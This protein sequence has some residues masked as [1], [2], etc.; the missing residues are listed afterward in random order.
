MRRVARCDVCSRERRNSLHDVIMHEEK[1]K[2]NSRWAACAGSQ[3]VGLLDRCWLAT[4][5]T[6][7]KRQAGCWAMREW[8]CSD[9]I[10]GPAM[11]R[12]NLMAC[13]WAWQ[14]L[15]AWQNG[16]Q[17]GPKINPIQKRT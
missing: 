13:K 2:R 8:A 4:N 7:G 5:Q 12:L 17:D 6:G 1:R 14:L 11:L 3:E 15:W 16:L 10:M 9:Q